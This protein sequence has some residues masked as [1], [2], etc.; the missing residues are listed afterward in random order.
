MESR[1][2]GGVFI[3]VLW[4]LEFAGRCSFVVDFF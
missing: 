2:G 4:F 3:F 1:G